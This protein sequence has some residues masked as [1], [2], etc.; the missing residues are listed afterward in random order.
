[1]KS[2]ITYN[3]N[4]DFSIHNI[5]FGIYSK[6]G[7]NKRV[8]SILGNKIIDIYELFVAGYLSEFPELNAAILENEFLND[9]IS[10]GKKSTSKIREKIQFI[11]SNDYNGLAK[12][13]EHQQ[14]ILVEDSKVDLHLPI[15]IENYTDFYSSM[16]HARNVGTMFRDPD[17]ALLPNWKHI[18][19]GYHGRASSITV[20]GTN[21]H[22]PMGQTKAQ[23]AENPVFGPCKLLDFELEMGFVVGKNSELGNAIS[24]DEASDY[25]FGLALFNDWSAR[26][27]QTWEYV[28]LGPFLSKNF[29]STLSP[30]IV[31]ME[32]LEPF[33]MKGPEQNPKVLDYLSYKKDFHFD[34]NLEVTIKP[35]D[36]EETLV[37]ISN[38]KY[39]YW[40]MLQQ[41]AHHTVNGCNVKVGDLYASGTISGPEKGSFGSMLEITWRGT[42]PIKMKDGSERKFIND[43]DT[44]TIKGF[45]I[46][47]NVRVGFGKAEAK[48]L[49]AKT[50]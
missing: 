42:Q 27:I 16:D 13:I 14:T 24:T 11:F 23:D 12:N 22:R 9:F 41:L 19:I 44:V 37:T 43:N 39:M 48:A 20:S 15:K 28:P 26:D 33:R 10:I 17:N 50:K 6:K 45:A 29:C 49:P 30:W 5:P 7:G 18:P 34:V 46:K 4:C 36:S 35:Q 3:S 40:N 38:F 2:W 21:F 8:A 25:I 32:A 31:T 47:D 1:M